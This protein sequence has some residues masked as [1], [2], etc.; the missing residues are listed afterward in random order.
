MGGGLRSGRGV[1]RVLALGLALGGCGVKLAD[2]PSERA[3]GGVTDGPGASDAPLGAWSA[4][5]KIPSAGTTADEDDGTLSS[6]GLELV[7]AVVNT[8]DANRKDLYVATRPSV[9]AA[10]GAATPLSISELGTSEETPRF[11]P[12]DKTLYFASDR[13]GGPGLLDIYKTTRSSVG[14]AWTTPT[15]VTGPNTTA[16]EKWFMPCGASTSYLVVAG[17]DLIVLVTDEEVDLAAEDVAVR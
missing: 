3:D 17:P 1:A 11:S 2:L 6:T 7:F 10:F 14:N 15:L 8:T 12:D 5:V 13:V 9:T 16:N 4:P